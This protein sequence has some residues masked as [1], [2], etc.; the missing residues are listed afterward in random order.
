MPSFAGIARSPAN[1]LSLSLLRLPLR[2][3]KRRCLSPL[4]SGSICLEGLVL[5]AKVH[6]AKVPDQDGI[7]LLLEAS[8]DH[9]PRLSQLW[10]DAAYRGRGKE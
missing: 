6:S 2:P 8:G 4:P 9:L 3:A 1:P 5:K 7:K 10:V